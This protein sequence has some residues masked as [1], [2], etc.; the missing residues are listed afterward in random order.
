MG[1]T[2]QLYIKSFQEEAWLLGSNMCPVGSDGRKEA[3]QSFESIGS[4][5]DSLFRIS[6]RWRL[7]LVRTVMNHLPLLLL[8]FIIY[9]GSSSISVSGKKGGI[10]TLSC[11]SEDREIVE[12]RLYSVSKHIPVCEE[13][14]CSGR[15]FKEGSCDVIINDLIY[16]DAGKYFTYIY[17]INDQRE[18]EH[19]TKEYLLHIHG[20]ICVKKGEDL[21]LDV[22]V[23]KA[24]KVE[25]NSG[26]GW[27]VLWRRGHVVSN[28]GLSVSEQTLIIS[29]FTANDSGTYRALDSNNEALITVTVTESVTNSKGNL[30]NTEEAKTDDT[31]H[32]PVDHWMLPVGLTVVLLVLPVL[33]GVVIYRRCH[34]DHSRVDSTDFRD[35][36]DSLPRVCGS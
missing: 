14:N 13:R 19:Q 17:Y 25:R 30:N 31:E 6:T 4:Q 11:G 2:C 20:E 12:I 26:S 28:D 15:V 7:L 18:L 3:S 33:I 36:D 5:N 35:P 34:R 29:N 27:T 23:T 32:R 9:S 24:D 1:G 22:L 10:V 8:Y 21:K 16:R